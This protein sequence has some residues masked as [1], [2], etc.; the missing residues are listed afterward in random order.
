[1][2]RRRPDYGWL[3]IAVFV[4]LGSIATFLAIVGLAGVL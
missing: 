3:W 2:T 4:V 1:M